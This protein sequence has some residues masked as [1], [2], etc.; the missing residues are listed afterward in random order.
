MRNGKIL[1]VNSFGLSAPTAILGESQWKQEP[2]RRLQC[3]RVVHDE[4]PARK[5]PPKAKG[6]CT[7]ASDLKTTADFLPMVVVRYAKRRF[8]KI[9]GSPARI[10]VEMASK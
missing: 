4:D 6:D 1:S 2:D 9:A 10:F 3:G 7:R 8:A 5:S